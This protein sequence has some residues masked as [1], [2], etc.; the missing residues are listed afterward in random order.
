MNA[1]ARR[2]RETNILYIDL[3]R[4]SS[5]IL[6]EICWK[7]QDLTEPIIARGHH[8]MTWE[9]ANQTATTL[10]PTKRATPGPMLASS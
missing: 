9:L 7:R 6:Y 10:N 3:E 1:S 2:E 5:S 8:R 4:E